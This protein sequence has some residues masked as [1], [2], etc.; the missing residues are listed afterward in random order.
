MEIKKI[1]FIT[2]SNIGDCILTLPALDALA[3][4]FPRAEITVMAG[5]RA[6]QI[7]ERNPRVCR[8]I[9]YNKKSSLKENYRLFQEL[10]KE[11]FVMVVDLRNT[12]FGMALPAEIRTSP[13]LSAPRNIP[14]MKDR[15]LDRLQRVAK[16]C[17]GLRKNNSSAS[18]RGMKIIL[19]AYY[20]NITSPTLKESLWWLR[21][22]AAILSAGRRI[23]SRD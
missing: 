5:P 3:A 1:L 17:K 18:D 21:G 11:R 12:F 13:F 14:H 20:R 22:R 23:N 9:I 16:G 8:L 6:R 19:T 4:S 15:H 2:L 7:F 10:K